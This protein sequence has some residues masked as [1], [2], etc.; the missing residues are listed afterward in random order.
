MNYKC[1]DYSMA[2]NGHTGRQDQEIG[3]RLI[4]NCTSAEGL[5]AYLEMVR[6]SQGR[7]QIS[8]GPGSTGVLTLDMAVRARS[9]LD[10]LIAATLQ[11]VRW[12]EP[13]GFS[14]SGP[15][16]RHLPDETR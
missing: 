2:Q 4:T 11:G 5:P 10:D 7:F 1:N 9:Q 16:P 6:L 3:P 8:I 14:S 13:Q 12:E 15:G